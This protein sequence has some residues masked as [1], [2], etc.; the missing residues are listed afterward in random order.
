MNYLDAFARRLSARVTMG[1]VFAVAAIFGL[2][3]PRT[4]AV[5]AAG[6]PA[7]EPG[8]RAACDPDARR[9]ADPERLRRRVASP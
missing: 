3:Y 7:E 8:S 2:L 1:L 9:L 5:H 4:D 6:G